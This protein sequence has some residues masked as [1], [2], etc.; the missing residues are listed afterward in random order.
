MVEPALEAQSVTVM[1][2]EGEVNTGRL[3]LLSRMVRVT[4]VLLLWP[5]VSSTC[6]HQGEPVS[7]LHRSR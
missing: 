7:L 4:V 6:T 1:V 3:S 2:W 5:P